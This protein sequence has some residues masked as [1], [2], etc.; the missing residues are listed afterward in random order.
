M[1]K[2]LINNLYCSLKRPLRKLEKNLKLTSE[3]S[4]L[5]F[6]QKLMQVLQKLRSWLV[7]VKMKSMISKTRLRIFNSN[8]LY[9]NKIRKLTVEN[10]R[11]NKNL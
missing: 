9:L 7:W 5:I 10:L 6:K 3:I 8:Q 4:R 1:T 11:E 2:E